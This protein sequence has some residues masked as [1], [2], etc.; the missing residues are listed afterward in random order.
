MSAKLQGQVDA[1]EVE[2]KALKDQLL[3][4]QADLVRMT[5]RGDYVTD[6]DPNLANVTHRRAKSNGYKQARS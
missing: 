5:T 1:L 6:G 2:I 4:V 3:K